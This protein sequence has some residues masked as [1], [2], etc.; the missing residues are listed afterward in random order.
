MVKQLNKTNR[1]VNKQDQE[2]IIEPE[3]STIRNC[4]KFAYKI[5][6]KSNLTVRRQENFIIGSYPDSAERAS[7]YYNLYYHCQIVLDMYA[8]KRLQFSKVLPCVSLDK[9]LNL[10]SEIFCFKTL[11]SVSLDH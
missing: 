1:C 7:S 10:Y 3:T 6:N 9:Y 8:T 5:H 2:V 11:V 4:N